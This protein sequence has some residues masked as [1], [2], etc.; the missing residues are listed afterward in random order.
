[1]GTVAAPRRRTRQAP[2]HAE[3][4]SWYDR[5]RSNLLA[6][7]ET[8]ALYLEEAAKGELWLQLVEARINAGLT[9]AQVAKRLGVSQAQVARVE[10]RGY[11][12]YTLNTL[13]K[14]VQAIGN[15]L[16]VEVKIVK[17]DEIPPRGKRQSAGRSNGP[18]K[19]AS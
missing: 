14:Y 1:M 13:R 10:K 2:T 9:Q 18:A 6:Y 4:S 8:R 19:R 17:R 12:S 11:E 7:P 3:Q 15:G 5:W 16:V